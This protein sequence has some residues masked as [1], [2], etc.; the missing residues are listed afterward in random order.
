VWIY[1]G[2]RLLQTVVVLFGVTMVTF[3]MLYLVPGDPA[4]VLATWAASP[5][6]VEE[7]RRKWGLDDP[8]VV[9]YARYLGALL[10]GDLGQSYFTQQAVTEAIAE[11]LP[12]SLL[13]A[14]TATVLGALV[15]IPLG[16]VS[17]V[18]V[19]STVD[20]AATVLS[21]LLLSL[22]NFWLGL[23]L[24]VVF[25]L[26]L[27]WLPVQ[28]YGSLSHLVLP[29]V[30]LS[31][32]PLATI[33]RITRSAM[34]DVL[35]S[36]YV[37]TARAKGLAEASVVYRHALKNALIP[38]LTLVGL[39][40][41]LLIGGAVVVETVFAWPGLGRF[42]VQAIQN[43]DFPNIRGTILVF[44]VLFAAIN[45]VVDLLYAALDARIRYR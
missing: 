38:V 42:L 21:L 5:E 17:A 31:A 10:R 7:L 1:L 43:R 14:F 18:R 26:S 28:G 35:A 37:R 45:L 30:V 9:Q 8:L 39:Q 32:L 44:A 34:L 27:G 29:A 11:R 41:G 22:P 13:L 4:A 19:N 6:M 3:L 36:D 25:S 24:I 23:V 20:R 12:R 2:Q 40:L 33:A 16:A 15:G